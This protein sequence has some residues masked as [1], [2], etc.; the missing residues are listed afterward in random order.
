MANYRKSATA[1][2][3]ALILNSVFVYGNADTSAKPEAIPGAEQRLA[4]L[5]R[6]I[7]TLQEQLG[8]LENRIKVL[9]LRSL[10]GSSSIGRD[11]YPKSLEA[12]VRAL[13]RQLTLRLVPAEQ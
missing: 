2:I 5:H 8:V 4:D 11:Y 7:S 6:T 3:C 12:R 10:S 13:E 9:E 1:L